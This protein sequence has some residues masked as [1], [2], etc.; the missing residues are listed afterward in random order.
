MIL[1]PAGDA[2]IA[3]DMIESNRPIKT[4]CELWMLEE[5]SRFVFSAV[6]WATEHCR[7]HLGSDPGAGEFLLRALLPW[8]GWHLDDWRIGEFKREVGA[9]ILHPSA[10]QVPELTEQL[11][12]FVFHDDRLRDP[13]LPAN[14]MNWRGVAHEARD[15]FIQWLSR[16]DIEFFFEHVLPR[17]TD[18]HGRKD[19]WLRYVKRVLM[20]RPLLNWRDQTKLKARMAQLHGQVGNYGRISGL[21]DTSAFLLD[22]GRVVVVEFS[23]VGNA[24]YVYEKAA[25]KQLIPDFW[26]TEPFD[27]SGRKG[28][29]QPSLAADRV[30]HAGWWR[31]ELANILARYGVRPLEECLMSEESEATLAM[32]LSKLSIAE[33]KALAEKANALKKKIKHVF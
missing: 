11:K 3:L 18:P 8:G 2:E 22:F 24:C 31:D 14:D 17:G 26:S 6:K 33:L 21:A 29:K 19:F 28:L 27:V 16:D 5:Q 23:R 1:G 20:S 15:R 10:G 9:T 12:R 30:T 25:A 4:Q 13:R 7:S 32:D